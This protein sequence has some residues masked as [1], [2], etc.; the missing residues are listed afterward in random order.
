MTDTGLRPRR[1]GGLLATVVGLAGCGTAEPLIGEVEGRPCFSYR[2]T[3]RAQRMCTSQPAPGAV[4]ARQVKAFTP[5]ADA[6]Q[7]VVHWLERAG[8]TRPLELRVDGRNVTELLPGSLARLR[9]AP[10][11]H[12]LAV[13]WQDHRAAVTLHAQ[14]G[15]VQFAEV[16][17]RFSFRAVA[18]RWVLS[19]GEDAR[20]RASR[21]MVVADVDL[22]TA[23]LKHGGSVAP[24]L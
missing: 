24:S 19:G 5:D 17:G 7:I 14:A 18:F 8:A 16:A 6:A 12:E 9:L 21:A 20:Q 4:A 15:P 3:H 10:G 1:L 11:P 13:A 2:Q 22:R 23:P